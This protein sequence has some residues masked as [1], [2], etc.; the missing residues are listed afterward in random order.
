[1]KSGY[2]PTN[3]IYADGVKVSSLYNY[4]NKG[5][6]VINGSGDETDFYYTTIYNFST[7]LMGKISFKPSTGNVI[8]G[9]ILTCTFTTPYTSLP[10]INI[11]SEDFDSAGKLYINAT[12]N[13]FT[14]YTT[15]E[16]NTA[17]VST[18]NY[19]SFGS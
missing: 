18:I 6:P 10:L 14:L 19:H 13:G 17:A 1:M 12:T 16:L 7:D 4:K 5:T 8:V 15:A 9:E 2:N 11:T 3:Q